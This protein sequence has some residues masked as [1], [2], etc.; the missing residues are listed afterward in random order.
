LDCDSRLEG[1]FRRSFPNI[2][3]HGTRREEEV[4]WIESYD[5]NCPIGMLPEFLRTKASD[6][7]KTPYLT[8]DPERV[9]QWRALFESYGKP[10][11]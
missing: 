5:A 3:V 10:V 9:M 6:F 1:L 7:P 2:E 8:P 4:D 11:I